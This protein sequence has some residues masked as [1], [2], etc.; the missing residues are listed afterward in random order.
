MEKLINSN[1]LNFI[2][3]IISNVF[4]LYSVLTLITIICFFFALN[5]I[6]SDLLW[7][8]IFLFFLVLVPL[9]GDIYLVKKRRIS[10]WDLSIRKERVK[11]IYADAI[12]LLSLFSLTLIFNAP[13][14]FKVTSL[15]LFSI[16]IIFAQ[17]TL[18]WKIS[19]HAQLISFLFCYAVIFLG[20]NYI[21]FFL[22]IP[23]VFLS[24]LVLKKHTVMQLFAGSL[25]SMLVCLTLLKVFGYY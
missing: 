6:Y 4:D 19:I 13:L 23:I 1:I 22:F 11:F 3:R 5:N 17:I 12:L 16:E 18:F 10:D 25:I 2:S 21:W 24:R 9:I 14:I 15:I 20:I 8:G 7:S